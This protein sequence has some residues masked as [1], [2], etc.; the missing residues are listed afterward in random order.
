MIK[1]TRNVTLKQTASFFCDKTVI[2]DKPKIEDKLS[3]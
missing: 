3:K 2:E 1:D